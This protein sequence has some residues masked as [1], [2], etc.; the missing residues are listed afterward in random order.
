MLSVLALLDLWPHA[1]AK[2]RRWL[3]KKLGND[4]VFLNYDTKARASY[5]QR[6]QTAVGVVEDDA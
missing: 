6:A 1:S 3:T 2:G 5:E 4:T